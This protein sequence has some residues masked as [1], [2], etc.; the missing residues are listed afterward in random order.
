MFGNHVVLGTKKKYKLGRDAFFLHVCFQFFTSYHETLFLYEDRHG[1]AVDENGGPKS[2]E[3]IVDQ[4]EFIVE[5]MATHTD[6][7][8]HAV[9]DG[10]SPTCPMLIEK[11]KDNDVV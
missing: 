3:Y 1:N 5:T 10:P 8:E 11:S 9:S 7:L 6:C 4:N 2:M